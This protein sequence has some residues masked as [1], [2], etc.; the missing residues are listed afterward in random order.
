MVGPRYPSVNQ[1]PAQIAKAIRKQIDHVI[2][3]F[4]A[5]PA[6]VKCRVCSTATWSGITQHDVNDFASA[7][8]LYPSSEEAQLL[9]NESVSVLDDESGVFFRPELGDDEDEDDG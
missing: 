3:H 1:D 6:K 7:A 5:D 4:E 2:T 8:R 9:S